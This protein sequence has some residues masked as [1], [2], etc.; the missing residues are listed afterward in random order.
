MHI[1]VCSH[2]CIFICR[3]Q[4]QQKYMAVAIKNAQEVVKPILH[5]IHNVQNSGSKT[6]LS[7][8]KPPNMPCGLK[9]TIHN[10]VSST[11]VVMP[12]KQPVNMPTKNPA[13]TMNNYITTNNKSN[14]NHSG[15]NFTDLISEVRNENC[16]F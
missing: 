10:L 6:V 13:V 9:N 15:G 8:L 4:A 2:V 14:F 5:K 11:T 1:L 3:R 12:S 16:K 7:P